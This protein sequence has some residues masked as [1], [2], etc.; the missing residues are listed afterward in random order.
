MIRP[1]TRPVLA[2]KPDMASLLAVLIVVC[3]LFIAPLA[4][5]VLWPRHW[6][7]LPPLP[8]LPWVSLTMIPISVLWGD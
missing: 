7:W 3:P 2:R 5:V 4:I 8:I 6:L 1:E